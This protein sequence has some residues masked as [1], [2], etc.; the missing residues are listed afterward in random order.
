MLR[1]ARQQQDWATSAQEAWEGVSMG[2]AA[3]RCGHHLGRGVIMF[4]LNSTSTFR[5]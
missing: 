3:S 5:R 2:W 1:A 4:L